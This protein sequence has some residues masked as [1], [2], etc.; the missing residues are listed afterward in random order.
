[1]N[2]IHIYKYVDI[3]DF[4]SATCSKLLGQGRQKT[5]I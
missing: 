5:E 4:I 3:L 2:L 1:M